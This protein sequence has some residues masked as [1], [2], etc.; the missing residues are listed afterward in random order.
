MIFL[1]WERGPIRINVPGFKQ[2]CWS[3][4]A[5]AT[6][7]E[8]RIRMSRIASRGC[9]LRGETDDRISLKPRWEF[10]KSHML[11]DREEKVGEL[12]KKLIF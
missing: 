6:P 9:Y 11:R 5:D 3:N 1:L 10:L 12:A 4:H 7:F 8:T 2:S